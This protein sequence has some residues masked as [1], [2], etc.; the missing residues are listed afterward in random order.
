MTLLPSPNLS[1]F[2]ANDS[3]C[4]NLSTSSRTMRTFLC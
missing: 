1:R 3:I 4:S 2:P